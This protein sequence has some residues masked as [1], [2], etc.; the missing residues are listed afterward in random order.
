LEQTAMV[1][2]SPWVLGLQSLKRVKAWF[3]ALGSA[4][5]E[6]LSRL[7]LALQTQWAMD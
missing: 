2:K 5:L 3:P 1:L 6:L 4:G 7:L